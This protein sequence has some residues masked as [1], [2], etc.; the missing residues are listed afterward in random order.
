M[1]AVLLFGRDQNPSVVSVLVR[2]RRWESACMDSTTKLL[3]LFHGFEVVVA[4]VVVADDD[5]D[6]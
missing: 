6:R 4:V 2:I 3:A 5:P 1:L